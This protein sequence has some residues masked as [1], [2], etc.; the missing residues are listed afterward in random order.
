M[1]DVPHNNIW[2][3]SLVFS[4]NQALIHLIVQLTINLFSFIWNFHCWNYTSL[5]INKNG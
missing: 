5:Q 2:Q 4:V 3:V 1:S